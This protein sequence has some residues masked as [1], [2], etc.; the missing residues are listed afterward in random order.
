SASDADQVTQRLVDK[1]TVLIEQN[2]QRYLVPR[3]SVQPDTSKYMS[4]SSA[5]NARQVTTYMQERAGLSR[6]SMG[7]QDGFSSMRSSVVSTPMTA[8]GAGLVSSL[9]NS[10]SSPSNSSS[11]VT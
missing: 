4:A 11:L 10:A 9:S 2:G 7:L 5:R 1:D 6:R 8:Y 3:Q